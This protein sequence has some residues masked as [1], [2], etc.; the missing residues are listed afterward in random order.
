MFEEWTN[1]LSALVKQ[2]HFSMFGIGT[3][4]RCWYC[5]VAKASTRCPHRKVYGITLGADELPG[6]AGG[7]SEVIYL[8]PGTRILRLPSGVS[9]DLWMGGGCGLP[10]AAHAIELARI[11]LCDRV[12]VQ[13]SG[14]V[15]LSCAALALLSGGSWVGIVEV[16][17]EVKAVGSSIIRS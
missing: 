10:T 1:Y 16:A 14:P 17:P 8:R 9:A 15:G 2:L 4:N 11:G 7:W 3:C 12:L 13:G 5:L 6:L